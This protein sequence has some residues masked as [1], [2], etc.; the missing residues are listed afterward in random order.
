MIEKY[1]ITKDCFGI[2][3]TDLKGEEFL[4]FFDAWAGASMLS[5]EGG[6]KDTQLAMH[7]YEI[8][9]TPGALRDLCRNITRPFT[10]VCKSIW[11]ATNTS[12]KSIFSPF[13]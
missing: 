6:R 4:K 8:M 10:N 5:M 2:F 3:E 12:A 13:T 11:S 7:H 9:V 1:E